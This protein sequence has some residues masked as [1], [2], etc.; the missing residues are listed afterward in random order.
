QSFAK[1]EEGRHSLDVAIDKLFSKI[2]KSNTDTPNIVMIVPSNFYEL[3]SEISMPLAVGIT[4]HIISRIKKSGVDVFKPVLGNLNGWVFQGYWSLYEDKITMNLQAVPWIDGQRGKMIMVPVSIPVEEI[5]EA[6]DAHKDMDVWGRTLV[7]RLQAETPQE[8]V[9]RIYVSSITSEDERV[10]MKFIMQLSRWIKDSL[11]DSIILLPINVSDELSDIDDEVLLRRASEP[12]MSLTAD[13]LEADLEL[14]GE[15]G[16]S[17]E[18][19]IINAFLEMP[20]EEHRIEIPMAFPI[21]VLPKKMRPK[22][23]EARKIPFDRLEADKRSRLQ[24]NSENLKHNA[25]FSMNDCLVEITS[26]HGNQLPTY[27]KEEDVRL[28][29]RGNKLAYMYVFNVVLGR[30]K[31]I[32]TLLFPENGSKSEKI[33]ANELLILKTDKLKAGRSFVWVVASEVNLDRKLLKNGKIRSNII[34]SLLTVRNKARKNNK[35]HSEARLL[36]IKQ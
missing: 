25:S 15:I 12:R 33:E 24:R 32:P 23:L 11:S 20:F 22:K 18:E 17:R 6:L 30:G 10:D 7:R 26:N 29:V 4:D 8:K 27:D 5:A 9:Q 14:N 31:N 28:F 19:I 35:G 36:L 13:L 3:D 16:L 21:D 34:R 2:S 1:G